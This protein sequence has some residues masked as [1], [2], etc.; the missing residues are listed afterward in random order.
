MTAV[1]DR[2]FGNRPEDRTED[3]I[4]QVYENIMNI[5]AF[6]HLSNTVKKELSAVIAFES[7]KEKST[8]RK[9]NSVTNTLPSVSKLY[10]IDLRLQFSSKETVARAGT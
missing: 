5:K 6:S 10:Q 8:T 1:A 4:E 2:S 7:H 9:C 3:D